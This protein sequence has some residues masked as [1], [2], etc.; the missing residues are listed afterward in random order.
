MLAVTAGV[1]GSPLAGSSTVSFN[2]FTRDQAVVDRLND[3]DRGTVIVAAAGDDNINLRPYLDVRPDTGDNRPYIVSSERFTSPILMVYG[4]RLLHSTSPPPSD[5]LEA[6]LEARAREL[7]IYGRLA[8][9]FVHVGWQILRASAGLT[10]LWFL[11][12][13][14]LPEHR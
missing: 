7:L 13:P 8:Y 5:P 14:S 11:T 4:P 3:I 12:Q 9:P 2:I 1:D 6:A 10:E